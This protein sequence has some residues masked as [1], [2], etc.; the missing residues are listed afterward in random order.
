MK[1]AKFDD[2]SMLSTIVE[3]S[4]LLSSVSSLLLSC[5]SLAVFIA[6][7]RIQTTES[8]RSV[9]SLWNT[10]AR[11]MLNAGPGKKFLTP[12]ALTKM[13]GKH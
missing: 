6:W 13:S 4:V 5:F 9:H 8:L 11:I 1:E 10:Q 2:H 7:A 3:S 12:L